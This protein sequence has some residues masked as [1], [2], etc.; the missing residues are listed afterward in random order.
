MSHQL[1]R[2][3]H[4]GLVLGL[5]VA[6]TQLDT[7]A[8]APVVR[9]LSGVMPA[10]GDIL[11][12]PQ[13]VSPDGQYVVYVAD[14]TTDEANELWVAPI[15]GAT[16][17]V[18]L[19]GLLP[20]GTRV[21][22]F[23]I[24]A[25]S[26]RVVYTAAQDS[27]GVTELYSVPLTGGASTK[28]NGPLVTDG[29]VSNFRISPDGSQVVYMA[30]QLV[31]DRV[32]VFGV[33][34]TG[35]VAVKINGSMVPNAN[36]LEFAISPDSNRVVYRADQQGDERFELYSAPITGGGGF[37]RLNSLLPNGGDIT[38][39]VALTP[40]SSRVV[41]RATATISTVVELYSSS[42]ISSTETK[43]NTPL[44]VG[45]AVTHARLSSDGNRVVYVADEA[46]DEVFELYSVPV[47]G[48]TP[49]KLNGALVPGGDVGAGAGA[50]TIS[51]DS[52]RVVY[53]ADQQTVD[54]LELYSVPIT[55]GV[56]TKLHPP[57]AADRDVDVF[58]LH[59]S[60]DSSRVVYRADQDTNQVFEIYSAPIA[61][62]ATTKLNNALPT[63]GVIFRSE[64][65]PDASR[66]IYLAGQNAADVFELFS[67]PLAGGA[68]T[69]V[70]GPMVA[71]GSVAFNF[72]ISPD[73]QQVV[74]VADQEVDEVYELYASAEEPSRVYL[75]LIVR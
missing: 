48:G 45:R 28:L 65:T 23:A 25:D 32:E 40:D 60:P 34:I 58:N 3:L 16:P 68:V 19:S 55:G 7:T 51:P 56:A 1:T 37:T 33:P 36:V 38:Q 22:Q 49:I 27:A 30:D 5:V 4:A 26:Q 61:G 29:D 57:L 50:F 18:R 67:V 63:N 62:G 59:I 71:G 8:A 14:A 47:A 53:L 41:Y 42:I 66:V 75:P 52:S 72:L 13:Q 70:S 2:L 39:V 73:S 74:Y 35:G 12:P 21:E 43:L 46:A 20:S 31:N 44:V 24:S 10:A 17:P 54:V 69:P 11:N 9:K 64:I 6:G 15:T